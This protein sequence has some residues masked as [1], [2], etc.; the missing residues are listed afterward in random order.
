MGFH[1]GCCR[2]WSLEAQTGRL[3][4]KASSSSARSCGLDAGIPG[5]SSCQEDK[6]DHIRP[7]TFSP[8]TRAPGSRVCAGRAG[9]DG[10][11]GAWC[12]T[13]RCPGWHCPGCASGTAGTRGAQHLQD[14]PR[15]VH[16]AA[17]PGTD[18][19]GTVGTLSAVPPALAVLQQD[20]ESHK[21]PERSRPR[22][23]TVPAGRVAAPTKPRRDAQ[24]P[25][26]PAGPIRPSALQVPPALRRG[27]RRKFLA[28]RAS[29]G[30]GQPGSRGPVPPPRSP[31]THPPAASRVVNTSPPASRVPRASA[32]ESGAPAR[33]TAVTQPHVWKL[34][35]DGPWAF[36]DAHSWQLESVVGK[37]LFLKISGPRGGERGRGKRSHQPRRALPCPAV[38]GRCWRAG[39]CGGGTGGAPVPHGWPRPCTQ[40]GRRLLCTRAGCPRGPWGS[41]TS[42]GP[43]CRLGG[44]RERGTP[45]TPSCTG[46]GAAPSP[47][48]GSGEQT[49]GCGRWG[50]HGVDGP[51]SPV[52]KL[53]QGL[54]GSGG[55]FRPLGCA[56]QP[57]IPWEKAPAPRSARRPARGHGAQS[58]TRRELR[59]A[60]SAAEPGGWEQQ[61]QKPPSVETLGP[62]SGLGALPSAQRHLQPGL[63]PLL[64]LLLLPSFL[65][66]PLLLPWGAA[67]IRT[68]F[69]PGRT[70]QGESRGTALGWKV[71]EKSGLVSRAKRKQMPTGARASKAHTGSAEQGDDSGWD[72][73]SCW[74]R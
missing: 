3:F 40:W 30:A 19:P 12:R 33:G 39:G 11:Q 57:W 5:R 43:L 72:C 1:P 60:R 28:A 51:N 23:P 58:G 69:S 9:P 29:S 20:P 67:G 61:H 6:Q 16:G 14:T 24:R 37:I 45:R 25:G 22:V 74:G 7:G 73:S 55:G 49:G 38:V 31:P 59:E 46:C 27:G 64:P 68:C 21:T 71:L 4:P 42:T 48:P 2:A 44:L 53:W 34:F 70:A 47:A 65:L 35:L 66:L 36:L 13:W 50:R 17:V 8:P 62:A 54:G 32:G 15:S 52:I 18:T 10:C 56:V 41:G 26:C 63:Q